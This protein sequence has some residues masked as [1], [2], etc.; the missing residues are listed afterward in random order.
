[1]NTGRFGIFNG[2]LNHGRSEDEQGDAGTGD[3]AKRGA[4]MYVPRL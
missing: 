3:S 2:G 4:D 1:M